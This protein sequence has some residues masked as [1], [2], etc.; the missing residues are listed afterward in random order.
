MSGSSRAAHALDVDG[1]L[2]VETP[3]GDVTVSASGAR[4]TLSSTSLR[5]LLGLSSIPLSADRPRRRFALRG[6]GRALRFADLTLDIVWR[7]RAIASV[8]ASAR[9]GLLARLVGLPDLQFVP[10]RAV[11]PRGSRRDAPARR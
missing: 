7:G 6:L 10:L 2:V 8:G 4:L 11:D 1:T 9:P 3:G 5:A